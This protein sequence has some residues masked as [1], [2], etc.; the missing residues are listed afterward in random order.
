MEGLFDDW[1]EDT[2]LAPYTVG[3][4]LRSVEEML[5]MLGTTAYWS[6]VLSLLAARM[7]GRRI[8]FGAADEPAD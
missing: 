6:V 5:E 2:G 4:G 1:A 3:H 8:V 7:Q